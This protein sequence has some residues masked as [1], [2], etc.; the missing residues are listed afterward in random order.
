ML[1]E[2]TCTSLMKAR[3]YWKQASGE[4]PDEKTS[5]L[6]TRERRHFLVLMVKP[7]EYSPSKKKI[8]ED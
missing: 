7:T 8:E 5:C 1:K 3:K 4:I 6:S 2:D